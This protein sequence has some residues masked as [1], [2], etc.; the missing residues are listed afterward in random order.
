CSYLIICTPKDI[1]EDYWEMTT[2]KQVWSTRTL[3]LVL[4]CLLCDAST[5]MA[6]YDRATL[7]GTVTDPS[8]AVIQNVKIEL[9][10][11]T[12]GFERDLVTGSTGNYQVPALPVGTYKIT[13]SKK[14]FK[15]E[16]FL[17]VD[18]AVGQSRT[19]DA[20]LQVGS[21]S[22]MIEVHDTEALNRSSA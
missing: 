18:F 1:R 2:L 14:G 21:P 8:G 19:N 16:V 11:V 10:S 7:N 4:L 15:P 13:I 6:Q 12:T 22:E 17:N 9:V 3:W 20:R 5:A